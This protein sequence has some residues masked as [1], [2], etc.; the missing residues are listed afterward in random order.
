MNYFIRFRIVAAVLGL[1]VTS[2]VSGS[3]P[4]IAAASNDQP[5]TGDET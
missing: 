4:T 5:G 1:V 3:G 2:G